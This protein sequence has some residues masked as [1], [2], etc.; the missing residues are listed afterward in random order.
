MRRQPPPGL[1]VRHAGKAAHQLP[2]V[3]LPEPAPAGGGQQRPGQLPHIIQPGPAGPLGEVGVQ[4]GDL[5]LVFNIDHTNAMAYAGAARNL[6][7]DPGD[8]EAY[9]GG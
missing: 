2:Q 5:G 9:P 7:T 6:L 8:Q 4:R 1:D 3:P